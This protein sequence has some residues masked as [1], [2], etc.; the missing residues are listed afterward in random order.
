M[1]QR[2]LQRV[3]QRFFPAVVRKTV[4]ITTT[5]VLTVTVTPSPPKGYLS[6]EYRVTINVSPIPDL[7][8]LEL[9]WGDGTVIKEAGLGPPPWYYYH[10]YGA[11]GTYTVKATVEDI[12]TLAKGSG[13]TSIQVAKDFV[14]TFKADKTSG[15]IPL[16]VTFTCGAS[17]GYLAYK[18][19]LDPG[20][21][22]TP[23]SGTRTAEGT[24]TQKHTYEKAGSFTASLTVEDALGTSV[25]A[26]IGVGAAV[27][28]CPAWMRRL[29]E[30]ADGRNMEKLKQTLLRMAG[31][32]GCSLT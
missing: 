2:P 20:D 10:T 25:A 9:D 8:N 24:W 1:R 16:E 11:T 21:K 4:T 32:R 5:G 18:W 22:S 31:R 29:Y 6:T 3:L 30:V 19:T 26:T 27:P 14:V 7:A 23:Y 13:Q 17:G 28:P 12:F 15:A